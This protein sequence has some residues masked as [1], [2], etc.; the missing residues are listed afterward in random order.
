[1]FFFTSLL[2][3]APLA[4]AAATASSSV[5]E[6]QAKRTKGVEACC[7]EAFSVRLLCLVLLW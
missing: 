1:M 4:V 2:V 7:V 3:I 5:A 6:V